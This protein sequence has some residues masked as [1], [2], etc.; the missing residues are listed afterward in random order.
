[1]PNC[2]ISPAAVVVWR[3]GRWR[4]TSGWEGPLHALLR[5]STVGKLDL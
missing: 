3:W 5:G 1:M 4:P 2:F